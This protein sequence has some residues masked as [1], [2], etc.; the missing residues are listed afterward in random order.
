MSLARFHSRNPSDT[1]DLPFRVLSTSG[2]LRD[3]AYDVR[4]AQR[5]CQ[6]LRRR[7]DQEGERAAGTSLMD[8]SDVEFA[9]A[10]VAGAV[11]PREHREGCAAEG[12][13]G[14][15]VLHLVG[16][17]RPGLRRK[18]GVIYHHRSVD[19]PAP[20]LAKVTS[21][22][23]VC[24][25]ELVFCQMAET[26]SY[27]ELLALGFELCGC[28]PLD[29]ERGMMV[30][31]PLCSPGRLRLFAERLHGAHGVKKARVAASRVLA[32]SA[33]VMETEVAAV[34]CAP[35]LRGGFGVRNIRLNETIEF[36]RGARTLARRDRMTADLLL[37]DGRLVIEC[38]GLAF[39]ADARAQVLDARKRNA[40]AACDI[41]MRSVTWSQFAN[42]IEF[43]EL[44]CQ[45]LGEAGQRVRRMDARELERHMELRHELS[46]FHRN[47]APE[48]QT[49]ASQ[50]GLPR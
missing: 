4:S 48:L 45:S 33:S 31:H 24:L 25:P 35:R 7:C 12:Q 38:D 23:Y 29:G 43:Q 8:K 46:A 2:I 11:F 20:F 18:P 6:D 50:R 36:V 39:H 3:A 10:L 17:R 44:V 34:L 26:L 27:G 47:F 13:E 41:Q 14:M 21:G 22:L 42:V 37:A 40:L 30:R 28:Y 19:F 15:P 5:V 16:R 1:R 49:P 32:K 9:L